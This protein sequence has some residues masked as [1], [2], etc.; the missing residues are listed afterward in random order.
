MKTFLSLLF[1]FICSFTFAQETTQTVDSFSI[2][3]ITDSVK[4]LISSV[5]WFF[6]LV[7][8]LVTWILNDTSEAVNTGSWFNW[9]AKIP[10]GLRALSIGLFGI[11]LFAWTFKIT[12][13]TEIFNLVLSL[14]MAMA[15]Y[16][17]G[18]DKIFRFIS[19]RIGLKFE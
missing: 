18:V 7:F 14:I 9:F 16:K 17:L 3:I 13:R 1:L 2:G 4:H 15:V 8:M 5:N 10:K 6:I 11:V 12:G 19:T